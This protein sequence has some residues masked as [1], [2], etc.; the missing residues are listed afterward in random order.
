MSVSKEKN[1]INLRQGQNDTWHTSFDSLSINAV[2][3]LIFIII[4][5]LLLNMLFNA[6]V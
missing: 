4:K 5:L 6:W 3:Y 2:L 1:Y